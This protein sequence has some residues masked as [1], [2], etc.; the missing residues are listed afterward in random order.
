MS[1]F[2]ETTAILKE[3]EELKNRLMDLS[4]QLFLQDLS[5]NMES[6]ILDK[7]VS[8]MKSTSN[9]HS[10]MRGNYSPH[11]GDRSRNHVSP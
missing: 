6:C 7:S 2:K 8:M 5:D 3:N 1:N 9:F 11:N 10:R 4:E